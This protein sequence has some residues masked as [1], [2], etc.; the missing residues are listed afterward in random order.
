MGGFLLIIKKPT[1][2]LEAVKEAHADVTAT[3]ARRGIPL[4]EIIDH[5]DCAAFIFAKANFRPESVLRFDNGDFI[6]A[7]GT[8]LYKNSLG[9]KALAALYDDFEPT[10]GRIFDSL[11]GHYFVCLAKDG[12]L[13]AFNDFNGIYGVYTNR[14]KTIISSSFLG[15]ARS[16]QPRTISEQELFEYISHG[17]WYGDATMVKEVRRLDTHNLHRLKPHYAALA[18]A[19]S[20]PELD[21]GLKLEEQRDLVVRQ[22]TGYFG[23]L[24]ENLNNSIC[25]ALSGGYDSRLMVGLCRQVGINPLLYVYGAEDSPDVQISKLIC[26]G[27]HLPLTHQNKNG[28]PRVTVEEFVETVSAQYHFLD[29]QFEDGSFDP[30]TDLATRRWRTA[31][32]RLQLSGVGGEIYRNYFYVSERP[33][34]VYPLARQH[35]EV[36]ALDWFTSRFH[37]ENYLQ[38]LAAKLKFAL[39][40]T[41]DRL[42]RRQAEMAYPALRLKYWMGSN[43]AA[44]NVLSYALAPFSEPVFTFPS[45]GIPTRYKYCGKFEAAVLSA[46]APGLAKYPSIYGFNFYD[47][48]PVSALL[49]NLL[50]VHTPVALRP[51]LLQPIRRW[52]AKKGEFPYYLQKDYVDAV[53]GSGERRV[54]QYIHLDRTTDPKVMNRALTVELLLK[55]L[56]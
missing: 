54:S 2:S 5:R 14:E 25:S 45:L 10:G 21:P 50:M 52:V 40:V 35:F 18:K 38:T 17:A 3:I 4:S 16:Q 28:L 49:K 46:V 26:R 1:D 29:A 24:K 9:A 42:S 30:G 37:R 15:L 47:P 44:N 32:A 7:T 51:A 43:V 36:P 31:Q 20:F 39:G 22:L 23:S 27:E 53:L 56:F 11:R 13:Y 19:G 12:G 8:L 48:P 34:E 55:D 33:V 6:F 41:S